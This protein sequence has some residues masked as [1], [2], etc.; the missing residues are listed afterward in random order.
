MEGYLGV[1]LLGPD[2]CLIKKEFTGPRSTTVQK[3]RLKLRKFRSSVVWATK[4]QFLYH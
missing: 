4:E 1:N 2:P 3:H